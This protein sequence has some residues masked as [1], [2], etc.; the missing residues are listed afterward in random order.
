M[1]VLKRSESGFGVDHRR[2]D[3][4]KLYERDRVLKT[5]LQV[6]NIRGNLCSPFVERAN[7]SMY[8]ASFIRVLFAAL[9]YMHSFLYRY[10]L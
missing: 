1:Q 10:K 3:G 2:A 8:H 4:W 6:E 5:N 7:S 9:I